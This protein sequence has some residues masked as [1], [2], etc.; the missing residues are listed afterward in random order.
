[1]KFA[2]IAL[3]AATALS[4]VAFAAD[5][6]SG[7]RAGHESASSQAYMAG[8]AGMMESMNAPMTGDA[9][10]DFAAMMIPHHEGGIAMAKVELQYGRDPLLRAMAE[11]IIKAQESEIAAMKVWQSKM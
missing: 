7:M 11:S 8:M 6:M 1:M 9:D 5:T 2:A 4:G 10:K 3:A